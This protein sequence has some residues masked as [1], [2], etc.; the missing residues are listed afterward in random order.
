MH[1]DRGPYSGSPKPVFPTNTEELGLDQT[2]VD[3]EATQEISPHHGLELVEALSELGRQFGLK[4]YYRHYL[5]ESG[6]GLQLDLPPEKQNPEVRRLLGLIALSDELQKFQPQNPIRKFFKKAAA[7]YLEKSGLDIKILKV[8]FDMMLNRPTQSEEV[9]QK[10][11]SMFDAVI[12]VLPQ[13]IEQWQTAGI[14]PANLQDSL[15]EI[16]EILNSQTETESPLEQKITIDLIGGLAMLVNLNEYDRDRLRFTLLTTLVPVYGRDSLKRYSQGTMEELQSYGLLDVSLYLR[17]LQDATHL[18]Y[19]SYQSYKQDKITGYRAR[20]SSEAVSAVS[21]N[22]RLEEW[23]TLKRNYEISRHYVQSFLSLLQGHMRTEGRRAFLDK[24][25]AVAE[26][27]I[28]VNLLQNAVS[29]LSIEE[30]WN[31]WQKQGSRPRALTD[32]L[33]GGYRYYRLEDFDEVKR[34]TFECIAFVRDNETQESD[35]LFLSLLSL[36]SENLRLIYELKVE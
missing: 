13:A 33:F 25:W 31:Y 30:A 20:P 7:A 28:L 11:L 14:I 2:F 21:Y 18:H 17:T 27:Q 9:W 32:S 8:A 26:K 15:V 23:E 3:R 6:F 22:Q 10:L 16:T 35:E 24:D 5:E 29:S 36:W 19:E 1:R 12:A 4:E 34:A